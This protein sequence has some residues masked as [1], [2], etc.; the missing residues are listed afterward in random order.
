[1]KFME[2][3]DEND[4]KIREEDNFLYRKYMNETR[5]VHLFDGYS[6][7]RVDV[8]KKYRYFF[9]SHKPIEKYVTTM[10]I[11][12][13]NDESVYTIKKFLE[14]QDDRTTFSVRSSKVSVKK[15]LLSIPER[16][17]YSLKQL[18]K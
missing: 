7:S 9:K 1:M 10:R 14:K 17:K 18:F 6:F 2:A 11:T 5:L 16:I 3:T 15:D 8:Q 12:L 4:K 13:S